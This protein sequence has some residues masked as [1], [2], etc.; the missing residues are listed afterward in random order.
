[1]TWFMY[2]IIIVCC[3][4]TVQQQSIQIM[5]WNAHMHIATTI[6]AQ[7]LQFCGE[8]LAW[9]AYS[10]IN[11]WHSWC[12]TF[13][14]IVIT[15]ELRP[16]TLLGSLANNSFLCC[17]R[18]YY[19]SSQLDR[20]AMPTDWPGWTEKSCEGRLDICLLGDEVDK[21]WMSN[22]ADVQLFVSFYFFWALWF[23]Q[24]FTHIV[25]KL[26]LHMIVRTMAGYLSPL[27]VLLWWYCLVVVE[28]A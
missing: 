25:K 28:I 18:C 15:C 12:G 4:S 2:C 10:I 6:N 13:T 11:W 1:M 24:I 8:R 14:S 22:I 3:S 5:W 7:H 21:G 27:H 26:L 20:D 16:G 9:C 19:G 17:F 23:L